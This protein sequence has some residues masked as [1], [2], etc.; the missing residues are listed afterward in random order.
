MKLKLLIVHELLDSELL[1][2]LE[3]HKPLFLPNEV[4]V[5]LSDGIHQNCVTTLFQLLGESQ[6]QPGP[7]T[8]VA[9][10]IR[11]ADQFFHSFN[12][13]VV[14]G[15]GVLRLGIFL[16]LVMLGMFVECLN[17]VIPR[18]PVADEI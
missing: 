10:K 2:H 3:T 16:G 9:R 18:G 15:L 8:C 7:C 14:P 11:G 4:R 1:S 13:L 17:P 6:M 5:Q 12:R